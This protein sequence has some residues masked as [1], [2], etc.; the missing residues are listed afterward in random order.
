GNLVIEHEVLTSGED[1]LLERDGE[2]LHLGASLVQ[3]PKPRSISPRSP[4]LMAVSV[5]SSLAARMTSALA[6]IEIHVPFAA[7]AGWFGPGMVPER[8]MRTDNLVQA[9]GRLDRG[10]ANLASALH[11]LRNR[12]DWPDTLE[13]IR[14]VVDD[15]ITDVITPATAGG[16]NIGLAVAY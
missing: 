8:N 14:L 11:A 5:F 1:M 15:D 10:G 2:E 9:T 4:A 12:P 13:T 3:S 6:G 7:Q 16:G